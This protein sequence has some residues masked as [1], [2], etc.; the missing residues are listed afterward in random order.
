MKINFFALLGMKG[1]REKNSATSDKKHHQQRLEIIHIIAYEHYVQKRMVKKNCR[2]SK[3][4]REKKMLSHFVRSYL[5]SLWELYGHAR[6]SRLHSTIDKDSKLCHEIKLPIVKSFCAYSNRSIIITA[7]W[8]TR[9]VH[10]EHDFISRSLSLSLA[11]RKLTSK[12]IH[13]LN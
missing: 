13:L 7:P 10:V 12:V 5:H 8:R 9:H 3:R 6:V 1:R 2:W 4:E 11:P